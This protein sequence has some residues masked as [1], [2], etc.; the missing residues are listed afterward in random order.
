MASVST[1]EEHR[2]IEQHLNQI[3]PQHRRWYLSTR[4]EDQ[5]RWVNLGD[6]S[7]MLNLQEY[8]LKSETWGENQVADYKK[9]FLV[10][11]YSYEENRWGFLP[12]FGHE[13]YL[14]ICE[15]PIE[16]RRL[17]LLLLLLLEEGLGNRSVHNR[18]VPIACS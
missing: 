16:V 1:F 4:Q 5:N 17:L 7:Q 12:V 9:D 13:E 8:F 18:N 2:F 6:G 14:Y 11:S 15:M 3:D 10:Y